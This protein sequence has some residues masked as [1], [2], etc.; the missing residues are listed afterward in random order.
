MSL[1]RDEGLILRT[2]PLGEADRIV[3]LLTA[4]EGKIRAVAKGARKGKSRWSGLM[5]PGTHL[6]LQMWRGRELYTISQASLIS[7][8]LSTLTNF[9]QMGRFAEF[10]EVIDRLSVDHQANARLFGL[11]IQGIDLLSRKETPYLLGVLFVRLLMLEGY[12]PSVQECGGCG[13]TE[14][15]C[16]FDFFTMTARCDA[17]LGDV[18][19][20]SIL[21]KVQAVTQGHTGWALSTTEGEDAFAFEAFACRLVSE[22]IGMSL[23][24]PRVG[25]TVDVTQT[26]S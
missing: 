1:A 25:L 6:E 8:Q 21:A 2:W 17:C 19:A 7:S 26:D 9:A 16:A 12:M 5:Q 13:S 18:V 10:L 24:A 23:R 14:S 22:V 20:P 3:S 15:L 11:A 4:N